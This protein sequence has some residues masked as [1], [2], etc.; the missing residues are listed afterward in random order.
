MSR[1]DEALHRAGEHTSPSG[2]VA[3]VSKV[4]QSPWEF[5]AAD[6]SEE[7]PRS[8][9]RG[10]LLSMQVPSAGGPQAIVDGF[11][12]NWHDRLATSPQADWLL[13]EQFRRLAATLH[14]AQTDVGTR[15]VMV[16]SASAG[17]GKTLTA[18]NLA[19]TLSESYRTTGCY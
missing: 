5:V 16:T 15:T 2:R 3:P 1:I 17:D 12:P 14:H 4:F 6:E 7:R 8:A 9:E 13:V 19:L 11:N 10:S 18:I